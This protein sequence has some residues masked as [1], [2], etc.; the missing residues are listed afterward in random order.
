MN[1]DEMVGDRLRVCEQELLYAFARLVSIS[2][3]F[4]FTFLF[5]RSND[6]EYIVFALTL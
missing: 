4:L 1:C 2:S 3:N 6:G 5:I